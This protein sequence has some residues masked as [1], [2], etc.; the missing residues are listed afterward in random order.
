[1]ATASPAVRGRDRGRGM[2]EGVPPACLLLLARGGM[3]AGR[4]AAP[5]GP[6]L[7]LRG[8]KGWVGRAVEGSGGGD[9]ATARKPAA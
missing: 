1:M 9:I 2:V 4:A 7:S 6:Q 3:W 5:P 8:R